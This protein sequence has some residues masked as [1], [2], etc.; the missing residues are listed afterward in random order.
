[1]IETL[2]VDCKEF[3]TR[4]ITIFKGTDE[5]VTIKVATTAL[6]DYISE[7]DALGDIKS[8]YQPVDDQIAC[9][10]TPM[11][12]IKMSDEQLIQYVEENYYD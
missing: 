9:Y 1:M 6:L 11:E 7:E 8:E 4:T 10:V 12:L 5:Q 3:I 2:I